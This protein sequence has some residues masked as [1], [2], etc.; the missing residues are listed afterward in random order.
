MRNRREQLVTTNDLH[1]ALHRYLEVLSDP[2]LQ[3][4][5]DTPPTGW[6][7]RQYCLALSTPPEGSSQRSRECGCLVGIVEDWQPPTDPS[8]LNTEPQRT[9]PEV[10]CASLSLLE[11]RELKHTAQR[12][13]DVHYRLFGRNDTVTIIKQQAKRLLEQRAAPHTAL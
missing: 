5:L 1:D 13:F 2:T 9:Y 12:A 10:V 6:T 8:R 7:D 3:R 4:L 11:Y